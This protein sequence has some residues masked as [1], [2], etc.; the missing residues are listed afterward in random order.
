MIRERSSRAARAARAKRPKPSGRAAKPRT[1]ANPE[2]DSPLTRIEADRIWITL[3]ATYG[4]M[5][6]AKRLIPLTPAERQAE[7]LTDESGLT[8]DDWLAKDGLG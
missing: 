1:Y 7:K 6:E 8:A 3:E 2:Q 4:P 5:V